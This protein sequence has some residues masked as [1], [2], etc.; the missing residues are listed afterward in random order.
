MKNEHGTS[1]VKIGSQIDSLLQEQKIKVKYVKLASDVI[2]DETICIRKK[3]E[4][5]KDLGK[6]QEKELKT[7]L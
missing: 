4:K 5:I 1:A 6:Q 7:I 2:E 3:R